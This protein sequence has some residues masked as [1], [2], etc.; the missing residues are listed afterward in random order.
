M[1]SLKLI[2]LQIRRD[3]WYRIS[4]ITGLSGGEKFDDLAFFEKVQKHENKHKKLRQHTRF[5]HIMS[6]RNR[7]Y[8][9]QTRSQAIARI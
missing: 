8:Y 4:K 3:V 5:L 9:F 6:R 1:P 2:L 7:R